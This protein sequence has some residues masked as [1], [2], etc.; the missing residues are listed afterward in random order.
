MALSAVY[1]L[2]IF[3]PHKEKIQSQNHARALAGQKINEE[4]SSSAIQIKEASL[5]QVERY[6]VVRQVSTS[7]DVR[8]DYYDLEKGIILDSF[9]QYPW[10]FATVD[11][12]NDNKKVDDY[13]NYVQSH[14]NYIFKITGEKDIDDCDY[15][16]NGICLEN[17]IV[18]KIVA[19]DKVKK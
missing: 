4:S 12:I 11:D 13:V 16:G 2:V 8:F 6:G 5:T 10:F 14:P 3:L 9:Q 17:I 7:G 1:Y 18:D 15:Y 19:V